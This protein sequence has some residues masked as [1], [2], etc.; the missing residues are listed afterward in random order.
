[1]TSKPRGNGFGGKD[2]A[3]NQRIINNNTPFTIAANISS[4]KMSSTW[5][6]V[7]QICRATRRYAIEDEDK[8]VD[9]S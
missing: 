9:E 1:M 3:G 5:A 8:V 7:R 6:M 2:F 4:T